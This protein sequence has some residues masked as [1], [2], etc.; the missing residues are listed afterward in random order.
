MKESS[1]FLAIAA[2]IVVAGMLAGW[3]LAADA[4]AAIVAGGLVV[5]ATQ[6]PLHFLLRR[7]RERNDRF[8]ASIVVGFGVRVAVLIAAVILFVVPGRVAAA[9]FLLTLGGLM[10]AVLIAEATIESRRVRTAA[11]DS[12]VAAS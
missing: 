11:P 1:S 8:M 6:V 3:L 10:V 12:E 5:L 4:R 7:W 2:G 9:P